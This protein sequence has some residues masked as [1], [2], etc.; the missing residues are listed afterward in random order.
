MTLVSYDDHT[1]S[2]HPDNNSV[3][4]ACLLMAAFVLGYL[5]A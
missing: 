4:G 2:Y 1:P 5:L 3:F